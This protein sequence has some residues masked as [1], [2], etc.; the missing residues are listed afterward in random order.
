MFSCLAWHASPYLNWDNYVQALNFEPFNVVFTKG[1][2][3]SLQVL[4][5]G[6]KKRADEFQKKHAEAQELSEQR[7]KKLEETEKKVHQLQESL[8]RWCFFITL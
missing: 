4:L 5:I 6:E 7:R 3:L 2:L 8:N 1:A